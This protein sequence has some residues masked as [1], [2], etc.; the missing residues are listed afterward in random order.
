MKFPKEKMQVTPTYE[1]R[2][3]KEGWLVLDLAKVDIEGVSRVYVDLDEVKKLQQ[4]KGEQA[5]ILK[6]TLDMLSL[7]DE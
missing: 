2:E 3:S 6:K 5:D 7:D 4:Q 1:G